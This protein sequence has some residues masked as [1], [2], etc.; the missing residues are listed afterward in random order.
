MAGRGG[1]DRME[2]EMFESIIEALDGWNEG[3]GM[4]LTDGLRSLDQDDFV[5]W[6]ERV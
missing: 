2:V 4:S 1:G 3:S 5:R 6:K